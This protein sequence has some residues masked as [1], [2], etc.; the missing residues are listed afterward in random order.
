MLTSR[1][2][3]FFELL[4]ALLLLITL[5]LN[6]ARA[7]I[8]LVNSG[9]NQYRALHATHLLNTFLQK[10]DHRFAQAEEYFLAWQEQI[11]AE[12]PQAYGVLNPS[13]F[14]VS[15]RW[16]IDENA[17]CLMGAQGLQGCVAAPLQ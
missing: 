5:Q 6:F 15:I 17:P 11:Q 14:T 8:F 7:I 10:T 12:L 9:S 4:V 13:S 2:N 3:T 1:G 16:G